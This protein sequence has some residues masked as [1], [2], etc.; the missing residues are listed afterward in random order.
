MYFSGNTVEILKYPATAEGFVQSWS[1]R[2][3]SPK[4]ES[5]LETLWQKDAKNFYAEPPAQLSVIC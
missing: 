1:E 5:L 2:F 3:S 4:V